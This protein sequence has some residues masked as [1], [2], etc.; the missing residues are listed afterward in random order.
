[1]VYCTNKRVRSASQNVSQ[2]LHWPY[3]ISCVS[4]NRQFMIG[5]I[6]N[7]HGYVMHGFNRRDP[8]AV[9]VCWYN[10]QAK[11]IYHVSIECYRDR[12]THQYMSSLNCE[13]K[14]P[15]CMFLV[16]WGNSSPPG[17]TCMHQW[18]GL[19]YC[20]GYDV[21]YVAVA[22]LLPP[23]LVIIMVINVTNRVAR[24]RT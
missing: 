20:Q 21:I 1:M 17:V 22:L 7:K 19:P 5:N 13:S 8:K 23:C 6:I 3:N 9:K 4:L 14:M 11:Q 24:Y 15:N 18:I 12:S 10:L 16:S 2:Y